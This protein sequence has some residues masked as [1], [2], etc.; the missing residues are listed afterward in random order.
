[1]TQRLL[2]SGGLVIILFLTTLACTLASGGPV[3]APTEVPQHILNTPTLLPTRAPQPTSSPTV[4]QTAPPTSSPTVI[5][6]APPTSIPTSS[7]GLTTS[8]LIYAAA[9]ALWRIGTDGKPTKLI[10]QVYGVAIS[11][12]G[13]RLLTVQNDPVPQVLWLIDLKTGQRRNLTENF[14][15]VVCC[16]VWWPSRPDW[17]LFQ[18]WAP[19]DEAPDAGYLTSARLGGQEQRVLDSENRSNGLP[20]PAPDGRTIAY[21]RH[22]EAWLYE[23]DGNPQQFDSEVYGLKNIQRIASPAW[24][25]DGK[26]L[27]WYVGGDFGQGWQVGL[28]V[29]DLEVKTARL[30]H[31]YTNAGRGGWFDAPVWSPDGQWL[32]FGAEDQDQAQAGLWVTSIDGQKEHLIMERGYTSPVWSPD[33]RW[34]AAGRSLIEVGTWRAQPIALPQNAEV[35]VW[36]SSTSQ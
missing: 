23:W 25:S 12:D 31:V 28:A 35:V 17:V 16:P 6:T 24:S 11:P 29:F 3:T 14:G 13:N 32:A 19:G 21:D 8:G 26:Q 2:R 34:L 1:M 22:G 5:S 4:V 20:A 15:R 36:I 30:L 9:D 18:S 10:D 33:G 7:A 27:A